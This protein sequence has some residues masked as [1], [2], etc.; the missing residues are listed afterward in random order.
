MIDVLRLDA[1]VQ[2]Q[3]WKPKT[4]ELRVYVVSCQCYQFLADPKTWTQALHS[5][6][7]VAEPGE[8]HG[9]SEREFRNLV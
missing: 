9:E 7:V 1:R 2:V 4:C 3:L 5:I 6:T 8:Y